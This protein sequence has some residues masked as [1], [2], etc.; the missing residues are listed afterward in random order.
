MAEGR[1]EG[2]PAFWPLCS[3]F[4]NQVKEDV[5]AFGSLGAESAGTFE[6]APAI[7]HSAAAWPPTTQ[8]GV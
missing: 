1:K 3:E 7:P 8:G 2:M 6:R 5:G 4:C